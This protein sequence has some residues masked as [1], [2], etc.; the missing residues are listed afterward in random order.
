MIL[1]VTSP[2]RPGHPCQWGTQ[3]TFVQWLPG[4]QWTT[5]VCQEMSRVSLNLLDIVNLCD[6]L[7]A[8][9]SNS[10]QGHSSS[11]KIGWSSRDLPWSLQFTH[12]KVTMQG[13]TKAWD[14]ATM[15]LDLSA[16]RPDGLKHKNQNPCSNSNHCYGSK[17]LKIGT[18]ISGISSCAS[19]PACST[20]HVNRFA[21]VVTFIPIPHTIPSF[22]ATLCQRPSHSPIRKTR[23]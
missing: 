5:Q 4:K 12:N 14:V 6:K 15:R 3:H 17:W 18:G 9:I 8:I 20:W 7:P 19:K 13:H 11:G 2:I 10:R 21:H 16:C 22:A 23:S 1:P